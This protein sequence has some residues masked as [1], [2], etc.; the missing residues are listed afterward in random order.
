MQTTETR[1]TPEMWEQMWNPT[2]PKAGNTK[3]ASKGMSREKALQHDFLQTHPVRARKMLVLDYDGDNS[4]EIMWLIKEQVWDMGLLP[5]PN[6]ITL[7]PSGGAHVGY[8]IYESCGTDKGI[9]YFMS[10]FDGLK[11]ASGSDLAY[12]GMKTRNPLT[13]KTEWL[14]AEPYTLKELAKYAKAKPA[15]WYKRNKKYETHGSR[16]LELFSQLS[17]WAYRECLKPMYNTRILIEAQRI[18]EQ[19]EEQLPLSHIVSIAKSIQ[20]FTAKHFSEEKR[21]AIQRA[22]GKKSGKVRTAKAAENYTMLLDMVAAGL[23]VKEIAF[24]TEKSVGATNQ[25][26][27]RA[28]EF[29]AK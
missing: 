21:S 3:G 26:L 14:R 16:H 11:D 15:H 27:R 19:F 22:R 4:D 5:E 7:T 6:W 12:T 2:Y 10:V 18:N 28:K 8:F 20:R 23:T 13:H 1:L 9:S 24:Q 25:A 29:A 17:A